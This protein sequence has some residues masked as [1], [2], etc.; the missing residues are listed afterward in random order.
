MPSPWP[1]TTLAG[2]GLTLAPLTR[3]HAAP[4]CAVT[5]PQTF[6]YFLVWP[7]EQT[8]D[9]YA[10]WIDRQNAMPATMAYAVLETTTGRCLGSSSYHDIL[11]AHRHAEIGS[12]WYDP[13]RRGTTVNPACKL[14][15]LTHAFETQE[16]IRVTIKCDA[17]NLH[18]QRAIAKLGAVREGVLRRHRIQ[19]NG[20]AR[21]TVYFSILRDEWP[22]VKA[23]LVDRVN[24]K[25]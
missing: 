16:C 4:L 25:T 9:A 12:T 18:S 5:P 10:R 3:D 22:A 2:H 17:R 1:H 23:G 14:L 20:Y 21:D 19:Q 8:P 13:A 11:P 7:A 24:A 6:Q 15:M